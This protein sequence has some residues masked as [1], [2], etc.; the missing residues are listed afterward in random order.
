MPGAT[1]LDWST[2]ENIYFSFGKLPNPADADKH[3]CLN[4]AFSQYLYYYEETESLFIAHKDGT[5][6]LALNPVTIL[7]E[8]IIDEIFVCLPSKAKTETT[9][10]HIVA[11]FKFST[12][13]HIAA[14][15]SLGGIR[16]KATL[17]AAARQAIANHSPVLCLQMHIPH[18]GF[19]KDWWPCNFMTILVANK[20]AK[21]SRARIANLLQRKY[22]LKAAPPD[23]PILVPLKPVEST[24]DTA[25]IPVP[26]SCAGALPVNTDNLVSAPANNSIVD[27]PALS[28]VI[29]AT[30]ISGSNVDATVPS[31]TTS[32]HLHEYLVVRLTKRHHDA[33]KIKL[34]NL[35]SYILSMDWFYDT[36]D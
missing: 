23:T 10:Q 4:E 9:K 29:P 25:I 34:Y 30:Y 32:L 19:K 35:P 31:G 11:L 3:V 5:K 6:T 22:K 8:L 7:R 15:G 20:T 28:N 21:A 17:D 16:N 12:M 13:W 26:S 14:N 18:R 1:D 24:A 36:I 33:L 27:T 2:I